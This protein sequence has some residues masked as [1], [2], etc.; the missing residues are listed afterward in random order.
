MEVYQKRVL[1]SLQ[2]FDMQ[3]LEPLKTYRTERPVNS[4][5]ISPLFDHVS[6]AAHLLHNLIVDLLDR[7]QMA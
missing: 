6:S 5:S 1:V 3:T 2:L 4:A 7:I